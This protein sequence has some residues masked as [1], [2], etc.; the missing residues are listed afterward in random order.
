MIWLL[1]IPGVM[2]YIAIGFFIDRLWAE[3]YYEEEKPSIITVVF[4][5]MIFPLA[6]IYYPCYAWP[7][8]LAKYIQDKKKEARK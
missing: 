6:F 4:W 3:N 2:L 7:R 1:I 5:P 8:A